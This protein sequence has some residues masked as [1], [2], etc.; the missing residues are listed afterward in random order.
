MYNSTQLLGKPRFSGTQTGTQIGLLLTK[1]A[2]HLLTEYVVKN[3]TCNNKE[4][5]INDGGGLYLLCRPHGSKDWIFRYSSSITGTRRKQTIGSYPDTSLK[6]ARRLAANKRQMLDN[7]KDPIVEYDR[8]VEYQQKLLAEEQSRNA[9]TINAVFYDW[10]ADDLKNLSDKGNAIERAF[11]KDVFP[12]HGKTAISLVTRRDIKDILDRPLK[13]GSNRMANQLLSYL[14]QFFA[15]ADEEE[16]TTNDPTRRLKKEKIGGRELPKERHLSKK[17]IKL[18]AE[19]LKASDV[20]LAYQHAAWALLATGC[21]VNELAR[22]EISDIDL[23]EW[24]FK[25]PGRNAKNRK[26]HTIY[27]SDF[28]IF[29]FKALIK[30]SPSDKLLFPSEKGEGPIDRLTITKQFTDRQPKEK[31]IKGR[32]NNTM[33]ELSGGH[34]TS[35]DL[36]RTAATL[37]QEL[38]VEPHVIKKCLNQKPRDRIEM[39]YQRADLIGKQK[40]A[41]KLLGNVLSAF[42]N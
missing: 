16:I 42:T 4:L 40:E 33:L 10:K 32:V 41:F 27:L 26:M 35:H 25:I 22:A 39:T 1:T 9:K 18:L 15:Y 20:G 14:K 37:M 3:A 13:R 17:E 34:W 24:T 11:I 19:R 12:L 30:L 21:R 28:A 7:G 36:R 31:K 29:H 5:L 2:I 38:G 6:D 8:E 23:H